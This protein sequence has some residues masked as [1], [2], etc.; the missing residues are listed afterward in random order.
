MTPKRIEPGG[1]RQSGGATYPLVKTGE[2]YASIA[3]CCSEGMRRLRKRLHL[4]HE[5]FDTQAYQVRR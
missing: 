1:L 4:L 3:D 5:C 2:V